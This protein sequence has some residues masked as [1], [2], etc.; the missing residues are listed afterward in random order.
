MPDYSG[1]AD[2]NVRDKDDKTPLHRTAENND[3][4][5]AE[6]L[7]NHDAIV[8]PEVASAHRSL[9]NQCEKFETYV[10]KL[11]ASPL[12]SLRPYEFYEYAPIALE[13]ADVH[14]QFQ[15]ARSYEDKAYE[16]EVIKADIALSQQKSRYDADVAK[17]DEVL[18]QQK[19]RLENNAVRD[20]VEVQQQVLSYQSEA[21]KVDVRLGVK[22]INAKKFV[23]N[24][25]TIERIDSEISFSEVSDSI[26]R[27]GKAPDLG[28]YAVV[29]FAFAVSFFWIG[30]HFDSLAGALAFV[31]VVLISTLTIFF[32]KKRRLAN[33]LRQLDSVAIAKYSLI[34][35]EMQSAVARASAECDNQVANAVSRRDQAVAERDNQVADAVSRRDQAVAERDNQVANAVS[36]RDQAVAYIEE[37]YQSFD[38][39]LCLC[40]DKFQQLLDT[41][42]TANADVVSLLDEN[43]V[44][45]VSENGDRIGPRL[46]RVGTAGI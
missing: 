19:S 9:Q 13:C 20:I 25:T 41:W 30:I 31:F 28:N 24:G 29:F 34:R 45:T 36:R 17:A 15:A 7:L 21:R 37:E 42:T 27:A 8:T 3:Y 44:Q 2:I 12:Q 43:R 32:L 18:S 40:M 38:A 22:N 5:T 11:C 39:R 35:K 46:T 26:L 10:D 6:V 14:S 1:S 4:S 23:K 33:A 16:A